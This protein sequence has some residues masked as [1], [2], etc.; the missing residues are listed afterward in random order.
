VRAFSAFNAREQMDTMR[1]KAMG[2]TFSWSASARA[3]ET[4]YKA[5]A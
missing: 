5:A 2:Q 1:R 3:Y 4:L